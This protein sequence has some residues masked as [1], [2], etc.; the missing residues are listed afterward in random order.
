MHLDQMFDDR[1]AKAE[2]SLGAICIGVAL[3][4]SASAFLVTATMPPQQGTSIFSTVM[5]L[6]SDLL[7][8]SVSFWV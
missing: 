8:S 4:E 5:L 3:P 1:E 7:N 2:T 6:M